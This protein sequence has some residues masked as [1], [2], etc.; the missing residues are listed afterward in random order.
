MNNKNKI[1][2]GSS[3]EYFV[4]AELERRGFTIALPMANT[5]LFDI[6]AINRETHTQ[7]AIQVKTKSYKEKKKNRESWQVGK[8]AFNLKSKNCFYIFVIIEEL[9]N[10]EYF[11][12]PCSKVAKS[13]KDDYDKWINTPG[14]NGQQHKENSIVKFTIKTDKE[15]EKYKDNWEVLL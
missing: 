13:V 1:S 2:V 4:A 14:K 5:E 6:L 8:K 10:P 7:V 15:Y 11:I 12:I 3:G 9:N